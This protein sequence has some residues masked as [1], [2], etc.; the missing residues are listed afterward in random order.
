MEKVE[1]FAECPTC[2]WQIV[3]KFAGNIIGGPT[4]KKKV[5]CVEVV[6]TY[7]SIHHAINLISIIIIINLFT[8]IFLF[9]ILADSF[10]TLF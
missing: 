8:M 7:F 1:Q 3:L 5:H 4:K 9:T 6:L 2:Y 10:I